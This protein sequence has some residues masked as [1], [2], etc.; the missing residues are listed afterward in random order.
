LTELKLDGQPFPQGIEV[1]LLQAAS[2]EK[3]ILPVLTMDKP[4]TAI[5]HQLLNRSFHKTPR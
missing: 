1:Q 2:V 5:V 3:N 4:K